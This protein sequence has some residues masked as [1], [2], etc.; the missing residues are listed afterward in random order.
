M[1]QKRWL[2]A[3]VVLL[4]AAAALMMYGEKQEAPPPKVE[5]H[6]PRYQ[7]QA[8]FQRME[9]R[10]TLPTPTPSVSAPPQQPQG[11]QRPRD[12]LLAALTTTT[13]GSVMVIEANAIRYSPV[14]Q[15][16]IECLTANDPEHN[17]IEQLKKKAGVDVL[18]DLDRVAMMNE[19]ILLSGN[20]AQAKWEELEKQGYRGTPYGNKATLYEAPV[21]EGTQRR[22]HFV[23]WGGQMLYVTDNVDSAKAVV[24]QLEGRA[25]PRPSL[26][27]EEQ[28]YGEVYGVLSTQD[29][30]AAFGSEQRDL[31]QKLQQTAQ[32]VELHVDTSQDVGVVA[33]VHGSDTGQIED[34]AKSLGGVLALARMQAQANGEKNQAELLD[35]A[36]VRPQGTQFKMEMALPLSVIEKQLA[37]CR[38]R[39]ASLEAKPQTP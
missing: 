33:D 32:R 29:L 10:R 34:L 7:K 39:K 27:S 8:E 15:M 25:E 12:P 17:P 9:Q 26:L 31:M 1:Q 18:Q 13:K 36:H 38:N 21:Q 20:F 35:L 5:V 24:D 11:P 3:A 16:L 22:E 37:V 6:F 28:T 30:A 2:I 4:A 23:A 14:G 19:G